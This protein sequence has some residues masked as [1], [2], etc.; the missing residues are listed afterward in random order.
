MTTPP[1][2]GGVKWFVRPDALPASHEVLE[3]FRAAADAVTSAQHA[4]AGNAR[5]LQDIGSRVA[6]WLDAT[7]ATALRTPEEVHNAMAT[8]T[9]PRDQDGA[10]KQE[11][12]QPPP[13]APADTAVH[14]SA[15]AGAPQTTTE[16]VVDGP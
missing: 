12:L 2:T 5:D 8:N 13:T 4:G 3:S 11:P 10:V 1:C 7:D 15:D 14:V 9:K 16:K 6:I